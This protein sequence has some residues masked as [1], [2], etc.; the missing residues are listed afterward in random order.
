MKYKNH[1]DYLLVQNNDCFE[2]FIQGGIV[3]SSHNVSTGASFRTVNGK[4][5]VFHSSNDF[6]NN[7]N[8]R[9]YIN[10]EQVL[11]FL[12]NRSYRQSDIVLPHNFY[13]NVIEMFSTLGNVS[14]I[15]INIKSDEQIDVLLRIDKNSYVNNVIRMLSANI[16]AL[17]NISDYPILIKREFILSQQQEL[18]I[19]LYEKIKDI[20]A[21]YLPYVKLPYRDV[22]HCDYDFLLPAG[23]GG[24]IIHEA[25]GHGLEADCYYL[26][27]GILSEKWQKKV[28]DASVCISDS[29]AQSNAINLD[30]SSDGS[31]TSNV[32]LIKNGRIEGLMSD[33]QTARIWGISDTGNGRSSSY[34]YLAIPRMRNTFLHNG[35]Y[36][37]EDIISE[38]NNGIYAIDVGAGQVDIGSGDFVFNIQSGYFIE[39]G[40]PV[41]LAKPFLFKGNTLD[42]LYKIDMIGNDLKFQ[43]AAC[44]KQGQLLMVTYGQPTIRISKQ[45]LGG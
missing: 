4:Q 12:N 26:G 34:E 43:L 15:S 20:V 36:S 40:I 13:D 39:N 35:V 16:S 21:N 23:R 10:K 19:Q 31:S 11:N 7:G 38:T 17:I 22:A 33:K 37:H 29:C 9:S 25:I 2:V 41:A 8:F 45:K 28:A 6:W 3:Q 27:K 14:N 24:I 32:E 5:S 30:Y 44:G 42:T 1:L 18:E